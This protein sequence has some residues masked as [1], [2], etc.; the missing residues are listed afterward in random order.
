[1]GPSAPASAPPS[2]PLVPSMPNSTPLVVDSRVILLDSTKHVAIRD[3]SA[4]AVGRFVFEL[5]D[6]AQAIPVGARVL[7]PAHG[8]AIGVV[9]Q[10]TIGGLR[11]AVYVVPARLSDLFKAG[12]F[13]VNVPLA[14][15]VPGANLS[16]GANALAGFSFDN[17]IAL[18][19][20][21]RLGG[22]DWVC[23]S[24]S[25]VAGCAGLSLE[26]AGS[27]LFGNSVRCEGDIATRYL[28][29]FVQMD[30]GGSLEVFLDA[31]GSV[32]ATVERTLWTADADFPVLLIGTVPVITATLELRAKA[33]VGI[34]G[35]MSM[36]GRLGA[37]MSVK[38]WFRHDARSANAFSAGLDVTPSWSMNRPEV[39]GAAAASISMTP[40]QPTVVVRVG[41]KRTAI[42]ADVGATFAL[43][44]TLSFSMTPRPSAS[45]LDLDLAVMGSATISF[46][47][48]AFWGLDHSFSAVEDF[49][50]RTLGR[51]TVD[52]GPPVT[53]TL[54]LTVTPNATETVAPGGAVFTTIRATDQ[55]GSPVVGVTVLVT[56]FLQGGLTATYT[57]G[58]D[59]ISTYATMVPAN[60][61]SGSYSLSFGGT[62]TGYTA[63]T[64]S[65]TIVV[66][67]VTPTPALTLTVTPTAVQ[68]KDWGETVQ[69]QITTTDASGTGVSATVA[70][71][72]PFTAQSYQVTTAANGTATRT[73]TVPNGMANGLQNITF[74]ASKPGYT[75]SATLTRQVNVQHTVVTTGTVGATL[76]NVNGVNAAASGSYFLLYN[77]TRAA[78]G[79]NPAVF[80]NVS[81]GTHLI[82]GY[83]TGTFWGREFWTSRNVNVIAAS[84]V[85]TVL[86]RDYPYAS[87]VEI[88]NNATNALINPGQVVPAGTTLRAEITVRNDVP[89][90]QLSSTVRFVF[91]RSRSE[92]Y[93]SDYT[94]APRDISGGGGTRFYVS[95]FTPAASGQYYY[96]LAVTTMINGS[97][98]LTD[99]WSWNQTATRP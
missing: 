51:W 22:P 78:S 45:M 61:A 86:T 59:G 23:A 50:S 93:D 14:T 56:D 63:A 98:V 90:T 15:S 65:R 30:M 72:D 69:Y 73:I 83:S 25:T 46:Y 44:P 97:S 34:S 92:S 62:K 96:S 35:E 7:S 87:L 24:G 48:Q 75:N 8:R 41:T 77:P 1:M 33:S 91:D 58:S 32:S 12:S 94:T 40:L 21:V 76:R 88:R 18:F 13:V 28:Y 82:E 2:P 89:G 66:P 74:M 42:L 55:T 54:T 17:G 9:T 16:T 70:G 71:S 47:E 68:T 31:R 79:S 85:S 26:F 99:S 67:P 81:A 52:L 27:M 57:T 64:A 4:E 84:T 29:C 43:A 36:R 39:T 11:N 53:P 60:M 95:V 20:S 3:S 49:G 19:N 6:G 38:P 10:S 80:T 37:G 5:R